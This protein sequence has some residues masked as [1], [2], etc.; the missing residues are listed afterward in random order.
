MRLPEH[1][2]EEL[3]EPA[4]GSRFGAKPPLFVHDVALGVELAEH[5]PEKPLRFHP[6]PEL[7][8]VRGHGD[9][10]DGDVVARERVHPG[11]AGFG[12]DLVELVLDH[13]RPL[14]LDELVETT[15]ELDEFSRTCVGAER[16]VDLAEAVTLS[17]AAVDFADLFLELFLLF[18]D[19]SILDEVRRAD[20]VAALEHHVLEKMA[21]AGNAR[22]FVCGAG[23]SDPTGADGR[24]LGA[25]HHENVH[26]VCELERLDRNLGDLLGAGRGRQ[27][28]PDE[29]YL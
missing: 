26:A 21:H 5:G 2:I 15:L 8:L 24:E 7:E 28:Y 25:L 17:L 13:D 9:E 18:D 27:E 22:T 20:G 4:R 12:V 11:S 1:G 10:V 14:L 29:G 19:P 3:V 16:V 6:E 23:V